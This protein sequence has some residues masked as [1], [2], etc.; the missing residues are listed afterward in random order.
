MLGD[1]QGDGNIQTAM[2]YTK[3]QLNSHVHDIPGQWST[4]TLKY[5]ITFHSMQK[6][7]SV[8]IP[9]ISLHWA[10]YNNLIKFLM[11]IQ[12][13]TRIYT[14]TIEIYIQYRFRHDL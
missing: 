5:I 2:T 13:C 10:Y 12:L 3:L 14:N 11:R 4:L 1:I 6:S 9:E 8:N 7:S